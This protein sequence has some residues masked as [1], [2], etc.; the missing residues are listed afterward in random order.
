MANFYNH[1]LFIVLSKFWFQYINFGRKKISRHINFRA[2]V[3]HFVS[4]SIIFSQTAMAFNDIV[5]PQ[6]ITDNPVTHIVID[7]DKAGNAFIDRAQNGTPVVNI[8]A[9]S[10]GGV[11]ANYYRDF[12]VNSENLILNNYR[13]EA[14]LSKLGGAL[15]GNPNMNVLNAKAADIILNEVTSSRVSNIS[16]YTEVFGKQAELIIANP[17]GIIVGGAGFINTSRLS[18][19]TGASGDLDTNGNLKPFLL[20]QNPDAVISVVGRDVFDLNGNPVAYNLGIDMS[21]GNYVD[22]LSR[23]VNING[24]I[25]ASKEVNIKTGNNNAIKNETGWTVSSTSKSDKPEFAV[26]STAFGGIYAGRINIIATEDGVG[27]RNRGDIVA[28]M[29]DINYDASG[30]IEVDGDLLAA[31]DIKINTTKDISVNKE[32]SAIH[33]IELIANK[34]I[35]TNEIKAKNNL[36]LTVNDLVNEFGKIISVNDLYLNLNDNDWIATGVL[37][38]GGTLNMIAGSVINGSADI[39]SYNMNLDLSGDFTNGT[40]SFENL[41][42]AENNLNLNVLG[43]ITNYGKII[44][45]NNVNITSPTSVYNGLIVGSNAMIHAGK[46]LMI[47]AGTRILNKGYIQA[48]GNLSLESEQIINNDYEL[49]ANAQ[50]LPT[51]EDV[52]LD[53]FY[54]DL[55]NS[56]NTLNNTDVLYDL[57]DNTKTP[58]QFSAVYSRLRLVRVNNLLQEYDTWA[59]GNTVPELLALPESELLE[60]LQNFLGNNYVESEWVID[61]TV[62]TND[63][64]Q[65]ISDQTTR[66]NLYNNNQEILALAQYNDTKEAARQEYIILNGDDT[67]F[68]YPDFSFTPFTRYEYATAVGETY[69]DY[70]Q[71]FNNAKLAAETNRAQRA[72]QIIGEKIDLAQSY[73]SLDWTNM[74]DD[75][76]NANMSDLMG[77][78]YDPTEW[79]MPAHISVGTDL[80][81]NYINSLRIKNIDLSKV[82]QTG[83]HNY[84]RIYSGDDLSITSASVVHNNSGALIFANGNA[85]LN[86]KNILF[87]NSNATGQGIF[88]NGNLNI[89]GLYDPVAGKYNS[90]NQLIN[91]NG[92]IESNGNLN[93]KANEIINYGEDEIDFST[94]DNSIYKAYKY[95]YNYTESFLG[96][97]IP[98]S[99]QITEA[100]YN[101]YI[102][103]GQGSNVSKKYQG[104][105][106]VK[107]PP[108]LLAAYTSQKVHLANPAIGKTVL[109]DKYIATITVQSDTSHLR[110]NSGTLLINSGSITN[111]NS[112]IF[113]FN[114]KINSNNLLNK[115]LTLNINSKEYYTY[116]YQE[117]R[118]VFGACVDKYWAYKNTTKNVVDTYSGN[119]I[120]SITALNNLDIKANKLGN[121]KIAIESSNNPGYLPYEPINLPETGL[122]EIVRTG[123]ID[124]LADFKLPNGKYGIIRQGDILNGKY[125]YETD[126]TLVDISKYLGSQYFMNRIGIDP[127]EVETKFIGDAFVE[128]EMIKNSLE[129]IQ[130]FQNSYHSDDELENYVNNLYNALTTD[131]ISALGLEFGRALTAD[132]ISKLDTDIVWYVRQDIF[133]A[134]GE[135]IQVMVPQVYLAKST[136][137]EL[138]SAAL[139]REDVKTSIRGDNVSIS[140]LSD[141]ASSI[142][143]N[144]GAIVGNRQLII[145][146]D[147]INNSAASMGQ[148]PVLRG[149]DLLVLNTGE[150][151]SINN[152]SGLIETT[153]SDSSLIINTGD[154]NNTTFAQRETMKSDGY[155]KIET[156]FAKTAEIKSAG[157]MAINAA[158]DV[159]MAASKLSA[160]KDLSLFVGGDLNSKSVQDYEY[161]KRKVYQ[162][163]TF[164]KT[165]TT[166]IKESSKNIGSEISSGGD[167]KMDVSGDATFAGTK[168]NAGGDANM[169]VG[170]NTNILAVTDYD[171]KKHS[172]DKSSWG[173]LEKEKSINE[174]SAQSLRGANLDVTNG[175]IINTG[176]NLNLVASNVN[177]GGNADINAGD[178]IN[179]FSADEV[180]SIYKM[181]EKTSFVKDLAKTVGTLALAG[182]TGGTS[183][184]VVNDGFDVGCS[185]GSCGVKTQ[186]GSQSKDEHFKQTTNSVGSAI[187]VGGDLTAH[188]D[189]DVNIRGSD[190]SV[191]GDGLVAAGNNI[192]VLESQNKTKESNSHSDTKITAG[193]NVGNAYVDAGLAARALYEAGD[194]VTKATESLKH[195]KDLRNAG[196]A[197]DEAV[198]D[199]E[200]NL[201][202]A[203]L[204]LANAELGM[205]S[206]VAGAASAAGTSL[207]TGM[208]VS[209][210]MNFETNKTSMDST[211]TQSVASNLFGNNLTFTS[212]KNMTQVGSN[213]GANDTVNYN[214]G[215]DLNVLAGTDTY[216]TTSG[217]ESITAGGSVGNNAVQLNA[218]YNKSQNTASGT[219][220]NNSN[221]A[222]KNIVIN[223]GND[224]TFAGANVNASDKLTMTVGGDLTAESKQDSD[225]ARG[226]NW[227]VNV[228]GGSGSGGGGFNVG[229]SNH[230]SA[231]VNDVTELTGGGDVNINVAG[232]TTLTGSTIA[233]ESDK[234]AL[235]TNELE[236]KDIHDFNTS[237]ESGFGMSSN[238]GTTANKKT[239]TEHSNGTTTLTLK[240]TGQ[241]VE[242]TTR[243]TVGLGNITVGGDSNSDLTGLNRDTNKAQEITRDMT[244]G[245]LDGS[246]TVDNRIFS[247][248]GLADIAN[249]H[250]KLGENTAKAALGASGTIVNTGRTV[251]DTI[252]TGETGEIGQNWKSGQTK[253]VDIVNVGTGGRDILNNL[254]NGQ[255]INAIES[256]VNGE[257]KIYYD[258]K[259]RAGFYDINARNDSD[260]NG[261]YLNA[262]DGTVKDTDKFMNVWG[263]ESA[264]EYTDSE[265]VASSVGDF[266]NSMW[267]W[268]NTLNFTNTNTTGGMTSDNWA[269][270]QMQKQSSGLKLINNSYQA[271][272]VKTSE[273][274][275]IF[276]VDDVAAGIAIAAIALTAKEVST[277]AYNSAE[278]YTKDRLGGYPQTPIEQ[279]YDIGNKAINIAT[280]GIAVDAFNTADYTKDYVLAPGIEID[281]QTYYNVNGKLLSG[282]SA[283][284]GLVNSATNVGIGA[285]G[286][287]VG[288]KLVGKSV[289]N[290][291]NNVSS[292]VKTSADDALQSAIKTTYPEADRVVLYRAIGTKELKSIKVNKKILNG[293]GNEIKY[294]SKTL[295]GAKYEQNALNIN[296]N[297]PILKTSIPKNAIGKN[298]IWEGILDT[299]VPSVTVPTDS[300]KILSKPELIK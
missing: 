85:N 245:V 171:Y 165:T 258:E 235:T 82:E 124:P 183:L 20:S 86:I 211:S 145:S 148:T 19:V 266:T 237:S 284:S 7:P 217:S 176:K 194:A 190:I 201:A 288:G 166:D 71:M 83:I 191:G 206:S 199:A 57:L 242:Q 36:S 214:I 119:S 1:R 120:S 157:N 60:S 118:R 193:A 32:I 158:G 159:N 260:I 204:N 281:G 272:S 162:H 59:Q 141:E 99:R 52:S 252:T 184:L 263:H 51:D 299:K 269:Q 283:K 133:L 221:V 186:I 111:Y 61:L 137:N 265:K 41:L 109:T 108:E 297:V 156:N 55:Y 212:G 163:G 178:N 65:Q 23:I 280:G 67:G 254:S 243:A 261:V 84:G 101:Q 143:T 249:Q 58:E 63:I 203:T 248:N 179:I 25:L 230:D 170:G 172:V 4:F 116:K 192:N 38:S 123:A 219:T 164:S 144:M 110:S 103:N 78:D 121:G 224:A 291:T 180:S 210:S 87:N 147:E 290:A 80:T 27:I 3:A 259:D 73:Q 161:E 54:Q 295:E 14:A 275:N 155:K 250:E 177:V 28:N 229:K 89:N 72:N 94:I 112:E 64:N 255:D 11:S 26:D 29:D 267:D 68:V 107:E 66:T 227:G 285:V 81:D 2:I 278:D 34:V 117:C 198:R 53:P 300:L 251:I 195:M 75:I 95:Y 42:Y 200:F 106:Y 282:D 226:S 247:S 35:N 253:I 135:K 197:S 138:Y 289:T 69:L 37:Q 17:N 22:L 98:K 90:L 236:Y 202:M 270:Q 146:T 256:A 296:K 62:Q 136:L 18:L 264:H 100:Q 169:N 131:K 233:S 122:Q 5:P 215:N 96:I 213:V 216:K 298:D 33:N 97:S 45:D 238:W 154:L 257:L 294:F 93:V 31:R 262:A 182:V 39:S 208:Y 209:G 21:S 142:L 173:G 205:A 187:T 43:D 223:T 70:N 125:L 150:N 188:A 8:N 293:P 77:S 151:G 9:A 218:G 273:R 196:K 174:T 16:G 47:S 292:V 46:D 15:H 30:Y 130:V 127:Y 286:Y 175:L 276:G 126:P 149:G 115:N 6:N 239:N 134:N 228:S 152:R 12:N 220:Y 271:A 50:N 160:Q 167:L 232:K 48:I 153:N 49:N 241:E 128:H 92:R 40:N 113:G 231:W 74:S 268:S 76:F 13:G 114:V 274:A 240:K 79:L 181:H 244:T 168:I 287:Y 246:V 132:Q 10:A 56:L 222:A 189:N 24:K 277:N 88:A 102:A 207:G 91:Y 129:Q 139:A 44:G 140:A 104:Y 105:S 234:L 279:V 185:G 225:Y